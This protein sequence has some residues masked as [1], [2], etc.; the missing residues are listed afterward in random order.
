MPSSK[1]TTLQQMQEYVLRTGKEL[2]FGDL[3]PSE[4]CLMLG[5]E[6]GELFKS[7]R[8]QEGIKVVKDSTVFPVADE[9][10]DV[11][12]QLCAIANVFDVDLTDAF[13][14]KEKKSEK[15]WN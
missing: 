1:Q 14:D 11:L 3:T 13:W 9:L 10:A 2:G 12:K 7:I 6:V 15:R 8:K 5:E 4:R